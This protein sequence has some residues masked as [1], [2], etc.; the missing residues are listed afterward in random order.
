MTLDISE[1]EILRKIDD[2]IKHV[3]EDIHSLKRRIGNLRTSEEYRTEKAL[4]SGNIFLPNKGVYEF[5][6]RGQES[7]IGHVSL[8]GTRKDW[9]DYSSQLSCLSKT[10]L[11]DRQNSWD[12]LNV[13]QYLGTISI[14]LVMI[15]LIAMSLLVIYPKMAD[16]TSTNLGTFATLLWLA[17][18]S[19][20]IY[21]VSMTVGGYIALILHP[22]IVF[23]MEAR[24]GRF[25]EVNKFEL[26]SE[27][28]AHLNITY[29][30]LIHIASSITQ[31]SEHNIGDD[32]ML[33]CEQAC[34]TKQ[35]IDDLRKDVKQRNVFGAYQKEL[36]DMLQEAYGTMVALEILDRKLTPAE[37]VLYIM[38][39]P[40]ML[41]TVKYTHLNAALEGRK[42][43]K[44]EISLSSADELKIVTL[45][46]NV[47]TEVHNIAT[48]YKDQIHANVAGTLGIA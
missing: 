34:V 29:S 26:Y 31:D 36:L 1:Y 47:R 3:D 19:S 2:A 15:H 41:D 12:T 33:R 10:Y 32:Y 17:S 44:S 43:G 4:T 40:S 24:T 46:Q 39:I 27:H 25:I 30:K 6:R 37:M 42:S 9:L 13:S 8:L 21:N 11:K 16:Q 22:N 7:T 35:F 45:L 5:S 28:L 23:R 14:A 18:A 20:L 48:R 38:V